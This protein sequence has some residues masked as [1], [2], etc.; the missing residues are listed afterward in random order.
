MIEQPERKP[1]MYYLY[2]ST[3]GWMDEKSGWTH[4]KEKAKR[5]TFVEAMATAGYDE[6]LVPVSQPMEA[7]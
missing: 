3:H 5:L 4:E 7:S 2:N 1:N 6:T